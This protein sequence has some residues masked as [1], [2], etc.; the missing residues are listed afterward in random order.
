VDNVLKKG[1]KGV[2]PIMEDAEKAFEEVKNLEDRK[3]GGEPDYYGEKDGYI[4]N[5]KKI[6]L[7]VMKAASEKFSRTLVMEQEI[8]SN[9]SD[10]IMQLYAAESVLLRVK[11]MESLKGE[12]EI[13]FYKDMLDVVVFEA[14][15]RIAKTIKDAT[16]SFAYGEV[17]ELLEKGI[18]HFTGVAGVN[19]K[20]ARRRIADRMID[21]NRYCF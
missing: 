2:L 7:M 1:A 20:E 13:K 18:H 9:F 8:L 15:D 4:A 10:S 12:D 16:C 17:R 11:K 5:F 14:A 6:I 21:E 19:V 3:T